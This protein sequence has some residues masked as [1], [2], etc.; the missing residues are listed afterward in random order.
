MV[1]SGRGEGA[2]RD[3]SGGE[4]GGSNDVDG[5]NRGR[6]DV[7]GGCEGC[8]NVDAEGTCRWP[9]RWPP[10]PW[11]IMGGAL[12]STIND[13]GLMDGLEDGDGSCVELYVMVLSDST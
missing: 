9:T 8:T 5:W 7:T 2:G 1:V 6:I 13:G 10:L 3:T 4:S 11:P 12:T